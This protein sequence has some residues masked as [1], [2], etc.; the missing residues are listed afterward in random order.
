[1]FNKE[2]DMMKFLSPLVVVTDIEKPKQFYYEVL[3]LQVVNDFGS[4]ATLTGGIALQTKDTW[5]NFIHKN[6]SEIVFGSNAAEL[7]FEEDDFDSFIKKINL[8]FL[9]KVKPFTFHESETLSFLTS[10]AR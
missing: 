9:L 6:D 5:S 2:M 7:Y 10:S 3:G 4:N 1:M 8:N